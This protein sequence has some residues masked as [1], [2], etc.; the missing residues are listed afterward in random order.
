MKP[1]SVG[2]QGM[3]HNSICIN[4]QTSDLQIEN[5][6]TYAIITIPNQKETRVTYFLIESKKGFTLSLKMDKGI[7][8][9]F[10]G[11]YLFHHQILLD[12]NPLSESIFS[13]LHHMAVHVDSII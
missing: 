4:C 11:Q 13:I 6:C 12:N 1:T 10:S 7:T 9:M 2:E 3:G 8:F 5:D